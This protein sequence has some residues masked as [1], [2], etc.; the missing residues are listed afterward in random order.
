M[1]ESSSW[2]SRGFCSD[3]G[4]HLFFKLK[5]TGEYNMPV[6]LFSHL[7]GLEMSM[8]YFCVA[9]P[10]KVAGDTKNIVAKDS[11]TFFFKLDAISFS[12]NF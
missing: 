9:L 2:A 4:T 11:L 5:K 7:E 6:G 10:F 12:D 1:Y 3:C 8:Q